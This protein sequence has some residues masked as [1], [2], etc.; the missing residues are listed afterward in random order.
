MN[1][2]H[3]TAP[4]EPSKALILA[5][6]AAVYII[7]GSTYLGILYAI[8]TIPPFLVVGT[9]FLIAGGSLFAWCRLRGEASPSLA[10]LG[11]I[12]LGGVLMLFVG[13][14]AV[15]WVE[16]YLPSGLAAIIVATVPLWFVVLDKKQWPYYF[17]SKLIITGLLVGFAGVLLLFAGKGTLNLTDDPTKVL[18]FFILIVGTI[19]WAIGSL[20]SKYK[21]VEGS[22]TIKA[23]VQML[24]A[25]ILSVAVAFISGEHKTFQWSQVS[26]TSLFAL[27]YLIVFGSLIGYMSYIWL[28]S[29]RPPSLVGTYAYVNPVV[30]VFL[31]WLI[32][33]ETITTQQVLA[34]MVILAGVVLVNLSKEKKQE[35]A[36]NTPEKQDAQASLDINA[37][38]RE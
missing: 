36:V 29:V 26:P 5:A 20:Y 12:A 34:L 23:A 19:G 35:A 27:G 24:A 28:L 33:G 6:F 1:M 37:P 3:P 32:A 10:S 4:Q 17:S 8:K 15:T 2:T 25:G 14:G 16:Q 13:N 9:R 22:T 7:W 18:S 11:K 30:A 21:K 38:V 31:G